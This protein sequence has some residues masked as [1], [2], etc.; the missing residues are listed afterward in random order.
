MCLDLSIV[1]LSVVVIHSCFFGFN[2]SFVPV[3]H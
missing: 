2:C 3:L 1:V